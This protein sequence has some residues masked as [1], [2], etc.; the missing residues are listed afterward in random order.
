MTKTTQFQLNE[1]QNLKKFT[2]CA[3]RFTIH[4]LTCFMLHLCSYFFAGYI[5]ILHHYHFYSIICPNFHFDRR[6]IFQFSQHLHMP[7][8]SIIA[9]FPL[10]MCTCAILTDRALGG[11]LAAEILQA[12][13]FQILPPA[14]HWWKGTTPLPPLT[15]L[16]SARRSVSALQVT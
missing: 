5:L 3:L 2:L 13:P 6:C 7:T 16:K 10:S 14:L 15:L 4:T 11:A 12:S 1:Y 8:T 9:R